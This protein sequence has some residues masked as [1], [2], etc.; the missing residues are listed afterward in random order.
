MS[1][2]IPGF[3]IVV[4]D[5]LTDSKHT[6][7]LS[8][9]KKDGKP[10]KVD[11]K[12]EDD[13]EVVDDQGNIAKPEQASISNQSV[14]KRKLKKKKGTSIKRHE[15]DMVGRVKPKLEERTRERQ[16]ITTATKG[17]VQLFNIVRDQKKK[18]KTNE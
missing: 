2:S 18:L 15:L 9:A 14:S 12:P 4:N 8:K 11:A 16:L 1:S 7:L 10:V 5:I 13:F 17:V 6:K 3:A